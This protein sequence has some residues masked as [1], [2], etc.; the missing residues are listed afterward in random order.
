MKKLSLTLLVAVAVV[1]SAFAGTEAKT[2]KDKVVV[3]PTCLFR[4]NEIQVDAF[5]TAL[6]YN[7]GRPAWGGGL[8]VNYFFTKF[9][10]IGVE[11]DIVGRR[12]ESAEWATVG[13]LFL[14]YPICSINLAP[15]AMVG[16]GAAYGSGRSGHGFGHVGGGLEYRL[17]SNIGLFSDARWVYSSEEP[18]SG[19]LG[20]A[21]VRFAF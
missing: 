5:G 13:N 6:F 19:V 3:E 15:Y 9:I 2:F 7:G 14:R 1:G 17:T 4:A 18:K 16:G 10:G 21:G 12:G 20:R 8:A 11:Q